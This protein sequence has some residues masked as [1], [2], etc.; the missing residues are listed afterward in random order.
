MKLSRWICL[1][2]ALVAAGVL[3]WH[4]YAKN[5][6]PALTLYGN[7]DIRS[8]D[9]SFRVGGRLARLDVDE[10]DSVQKGQL[11]G[12]Q[13]ITPYLNARDHALAAMEAAKAKFE[14]VLEG[15]RAEEIAQAEAAVNQAKAAAVYAQEFWQRQQTLWKRHLVSA[16]DLANARS[17][18]DQAKANLKAAQ[19]KH[20][21]FQAG[22]RSQEITNAKAILDQAEAKLAQSTLDLQDTALIAPADGI[23]LTR[24][25]EPGTLLSAGSTVLS[26]SLTDPV[27]VRAYI[28]ESH[29]GQAQP[30]RQVLIYSDGRSHTPWRGKIGF[31]SPT[32]EF[33]PKS[34]ETPELRTDLVYRL[35][36]IVTDADNQLR[37]GMPV[38]IVF[39]DEEKA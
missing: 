22:S 1:L 28:D 25:V 35:R 30:G 36:I 18:L 27:W 14:L 17:S 21:Q 6:P 31:V 13:D 15:Y 39:E 12:E 11:I 24:A 19:D 3:G 4:Y 29:L 10:G 5:P 7:V 20:A 33:T 8:V 32:A 34:V 37:Q 2:A 9:I 26:L 23:I 16:N 38:T